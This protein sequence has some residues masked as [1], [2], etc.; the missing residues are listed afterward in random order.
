M[1]N[2]EAAVFWNNFSKCF[3]FS[4]YRKRFKHW[5]HGGQSQVDFSVFPSPSSRCLSSSDSVLISALMKAE[6]WSPSQSSQMVMMYTHP[7]G[8]LRTSDG[9]PPNLSLWQTSPLHQTGRRAVRVMLRNSTNSSWSLR[10]LVKQRNGGVY[11]G[12]M[13][14]LMLYADVLC[15]K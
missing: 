5:S 11:W 2:L 15:I 7:V 9:C 6:H 8:G 14:I 10:K 3:T 1:W 4:N 13:L 12:C